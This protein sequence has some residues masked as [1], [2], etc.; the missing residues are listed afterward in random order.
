MKRRQKMKKS[1]WLICL[2]GFVCILSSTLVQA[3]PNNQFCFTSIPDESPTRSIY[4]LSYTGLQNGHMVI[5][6]ELCYSFPPYDPVDPN[7]N[8][9]LPLVGSGILFENMIEIITQSAEFSSESGV[10]TFFSGTAHLWVDTSSFTGDYNRHGDAWI[11][12]VLYEYY[13]HGTVEPLQC[14]VRPGEAVNDRNFKKA[15]QD[16]DRRF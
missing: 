4:M 12:G 3:L 9:C 13:E 1:K 8:D 10:D 5:S 2:I 16:F 14:P 15:I 7:S 6:G 11:G